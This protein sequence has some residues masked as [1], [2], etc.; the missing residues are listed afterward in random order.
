MSL[1]LLDVQLGLQCCLFLSDEGVVIRRFHDNSSQDLPNSNKSFVQITFGFVTA[2]DTFVKS[3]PS[4]V[5]FGFHKGYIHWIVRSC[6]T[7]ANWWL[8]RDSLLRSTVFKSPISSVRGV[9]LFQSLRKLVWTLCFHFLCHHFWSITFRIWDL[10]FRG[11]CEHMRLQVLENSCEGLWQIGNA[12]R[13]ILLVHLVWK[14]RLLVY[15]F[16]WPACH[17]E[18]WLD[19]IIVLIFWN[20]WT[21]PLISMLKTKCCWNRWQFWYDKKYWVVHYTCDWLPI[22]GQSWS[23]TDFPLKWK[24]FFWAKH[25]MQ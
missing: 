4:P 17:F 25:T 23:F 8:F 6:T 14:N 20:I 1:L 7:A 24:S 9:D 21:D 2:P 19:L 16:P 5:K 18:S 15:G 13:W 22:I 11:K 12:L 3:S 10:S